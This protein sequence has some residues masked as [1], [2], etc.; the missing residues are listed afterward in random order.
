MSLDMP[1]HTCDLSHRRLHEASAQEQNDAVTLGIQ[2]MYCAY[3][4]RLT[5]GRRLQEKY[6]NSFKQYTMDCGNI[7]LHFVH[8]RS[9]D[10][11]AIPL[12]LLH[13]WPCNFTDFHKMISPLNLPGKRSI[14]TGS[15]FVLLLS[16]GLVSS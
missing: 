8:E 2:A 13:G 14:C 15:Q 12:V 10:H 9:P 4:Q 6:L 11:A 16:S 7:N 3:A 1:L 5:D